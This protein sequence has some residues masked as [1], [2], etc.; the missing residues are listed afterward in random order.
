MKKKNKKKN[1]LFVISLNHFGVL[2]NVF[3]RANLG[4]QLGPRL[5]DGTGTG[6]IKYQG[7]DD[8]V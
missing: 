8:I 4:N 2:K 7:I 6:L 1:D 5:I 3:S